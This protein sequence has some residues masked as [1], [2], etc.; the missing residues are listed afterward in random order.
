MVT[1][2]VSNGTQLTDAMNASVGGDVV[3]LANGSYPEMVL[4]AGY[5]SGIV[6]VKAANPLGATL[7]G[8]N[9]HFGG[10]LG[11]R[12]EGLKINGV[13]I[14]GTN[15]NPITDFH[16]DKCDVF[17]WGVNVISG[18]NWSL[19]N[20]EIHDT[21]NVDLV[22]VANDSSFFLIEN[23]MLHDCHP[24]PDGHPDGIQLFSVSG[25]A[26]HDGIIRGN[27]VYDNHSDNAGNWMQGIFLWPHAG[28]GFVNMT[29]EQNMVAVASPNA[30]AADGLRNSSVK[31]NAIL[32]SGVLQL[33]N[34]QSVTASGNI[35]GTLSVAGTPP[36][37]SSNF[38]YANAADVF[39]N[40]GEGQS[41]D[42][43]KPKT[44]GPTDFGSPYGPQARLAQLMG[45]TPP[46]TTEPP[47]VADTLTLTAVTIASPSMGTV[48]IVAGKLRYTPAAG[49]SGVANGTYTARDTANQSVTQNWT[50]TVSAP[51]NPPPVLV[52]DT[53]TIAFGTA[54]VDL[55]V[56]ANDTP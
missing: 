47:P 13:G 26:P 35:Y 46:P 2:N 19:T 56:L 42:R 38:D 12:W 43:F 31:N 21:Q 15:A 3:V 48:A 5:A 20:N 30:L 53:A 54:F 18:K 45:T 50:V 25:P 27:W 9:I 51:P 17:G 41:W 36:T 24:T 37:L 16:I 33:N 8:I 4:N 7:G 52:A 40:P 34:N 28:T 29:I 32:Y 22:Q 55:D 23:N 11:V 49:F 1:R 14:E 6:T 10:R 44:G 39:A